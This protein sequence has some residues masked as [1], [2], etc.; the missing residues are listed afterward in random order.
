MVRN[1]KRMKYEKTKIKE[2]IE[3]GFDLELISFELDIPMQEL[4]MLVEEL[5][6]SPKA[7]TYTAQEMIS[8]KNKEYHTKMEK[9]REKYSW[10]YWKRKPENKPVI[11]QAT[12][13]QLAS[14]EDTITMM[15]LMVSKINNGDKKEKEKYILWI[16]RELEKIKDYP[17]T[18]EQAETLYA[19]I[20]KGKIAMNY[21]GKIGL[22][23]DKRE[24]DS[25]R[26]LVQAID[27]AQ[28]QTESIEELRELER[29]LS[30]EML[31]KNQIFV[32]SVKSK[33]QNKI[34]AIQQKMAISRMRNDI[35]ETIEGIVKNIANGELDM[36]EAKEII[37]QEAENRVNSNPKNK[38]SLT[39][40]KQIRQILIQIKTR[41][42]DNAEQ[43]PIK[44]PKKAVEAI[45]EL[46]G[47]DIE[48]AINVIIRNLI[49]RKEFKRAKQIYENLYD[50][51]NLPKPIMLKNEIVNAEMSDMILKMLKSDVTMQEEK[52]CIELV[53]EK[54]RKR[55]IKLN[56]I[57]LGKSEDGLRTITLADIW[58]D[59]KQRI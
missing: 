29:K 58:Q 18:I 37:E 25:I 49:V 9:M 43:C 42:V 4:E 24:Q 55:S 34:C 31:Q 44:N 3:K 5:K 54:L 10:L 52:R 12:K 51:H 1:E 59:E 11:Q 16:S 26:K 33:I 6:Q 8:R 17:L 57:S 30:S 7:K 56:A 47:D 48:Q 35:P 41:L 15:Q 2:I 14:I 36:L 50:A 46:C 19:L 20:N 45:Q 32:G 22:V 28:S 38:F 21:K 23:I 39:K 53:E 40:E 27:I 13:E